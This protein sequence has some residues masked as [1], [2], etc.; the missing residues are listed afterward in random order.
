MIQ[1]IKIENYRCFKDFS[2]KD[3][4]RVNLLVG[5]N[6]SGKTSIIELLNILEKPFE[7]FPI[8]EILR[9]R[10]EFLDSKHEFL[11]LNNL[12][13]DYI[14]QTND[15]FSICCKKNNSNYPYCFDGTIKA[16]PS[17]D[18]HSM[19]EDIVLHCDWYKD[20]VGTGQMITIG[21]KHSMLAKNFY[22][23]LSRK[24]NSVYLPSTSFSIDEAVPLFEEMVLTDDET[25][26]IEALQI[27]EPSIRK[28]GIIDS[29]QNI[30]VRCEGSENRIR[31]D[32]F[33]E[34]IS[35]LFALIVALVNAKDGVLMVDEIDT[36]LHFSVMEDMWR[37]ILKV[38]EK[39]NVQVFTTT[40]SNDCWQSLASVTYD[41][42]QYT[43]DNVSI[44]RIEKGKTK[45]VSFSE[46]EIIA[47]VNN[48]IEV[49]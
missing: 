9:R 47:A 8:G 49:R 36:G 39:N 45:A 28:I 21:P 46:K 32:S 7:L 30:A 31:I 12:Y 44:Q 23:G 48:D 27:I 35:R 42:S 37:L 33:G 16:M 11:D 43:K 15:V 38:A 18:P 1:E 24:H 22:N 19:D 41:Y 10:G 3:L 4:K 17:A 40:H 34:G 13:N 14:C 26:V 29:G 20:S 2:L 25:I 5:K 6:N